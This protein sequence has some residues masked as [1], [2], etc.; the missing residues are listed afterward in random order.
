MLQYRTNN[1]VRITCG[2][3]VLIFVAIGILLGGFQ[4][5]TDVRIFEMDSSQIVPTMV[6][7]GV[8]L[9]A[10]VTIRRASSYGQKLLLCSIPIVLL[11]VILI[12]LI[13]SRYHLASLN[14]LI[15]PLYYL[16]AG[17]VVIA[18]ILDSKS[19]ESRR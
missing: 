1:L 3:L 11:G 8:A 6:C 5:T 18:L 7:I 4:S 12:E 19:R 15:T 16:P 9:W 14:S 13:A 2:L 10:L 17:L